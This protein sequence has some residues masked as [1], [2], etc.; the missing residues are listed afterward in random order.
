MSYLARIISLAL[1]FCT[2][3]SSAPT[4]PGNLPYEAMASRITASLQATAGEQILIRFDAEVLPG[5][6]PVLERDLAGLD[7][8]L[9]G[10]AFGVARTR[11]PS[12]ARGRP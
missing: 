2:T 12:R 3:N 4:F 1:L 10:G 7:G 5:F 11:R 8:A 9:R 6:S